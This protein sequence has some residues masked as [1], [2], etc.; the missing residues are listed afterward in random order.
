MK[1]TFD[2]MISKFGNNFTFKTDFKTT[3]IISVDD[4]SKIVEYFDKDKVVSKKVNL[5]N[6]WVNDEIFISW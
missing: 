6:I 3:K 4:K 2:T 1:H 5:L